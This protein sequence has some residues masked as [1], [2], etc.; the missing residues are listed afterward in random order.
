MWKYIVG[1][2]VVAVGLGW[3]LSGTTIRRLNREVKNV[4]AKLDKL[5]AEKLNVDAE[6][7]QLAEKLNVDAEIEQLT[8]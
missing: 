7:E 6:I 1:S 8:A 2:F 3:L 4:E 5:K